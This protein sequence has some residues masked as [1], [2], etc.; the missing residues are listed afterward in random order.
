M[1]YETRLGDGT[2]TFRAGSKTEVA[3]HL[4]GRQGVDWAFGKDQ[5]VVTLLRCTPGHEKTYKI[6]R[7]RRRDYETERRLDGLTGQ[8]LTKRKERQ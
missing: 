3:E 2:Q 6:I 4:F 7:V 8:D 1:Y 5:T